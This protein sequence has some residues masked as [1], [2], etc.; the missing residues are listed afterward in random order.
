MSRNQNNCRLAEKHE[1]VSVCPASV[2]WLDD[3]MPKCYIGQCCIQLKS[4]V[5]R[6]DNDGNVKQTLFVSRLGGHLF[7]RIKS[8]FPFASL[9]RFGYQWRQ[10]PQDYSP[11]QQARLR[12][13]NYRSPNGNGG[14]CYIRIPKNWGHFLL[15]E[16]VLHA[17][18]GER[19]EPYYDAERGKMVKYEGD[20]FDGNPL[21]NNLKNLRWLPDFLNDRCAGRLRTLRN[22]RVD[23][24][25]LSRSQ[26]S[27][28]Y[29]MSPEDYAA[30]KQRVNAATKARSNSVPL[31]IENITIHVALALDALRTPSHS[32][33]SLN[34]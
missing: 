31:T 16:V 11:S 26:L 17:W 24:D 9:E 15:H 1:E 29:D 6:L 30:F 8:S 3:K 33:N 10:V 28:L 12:G 34:S 22:W 13:G 23:T 4:C 7:T 25:F 19:P 27:R 14:S 2:Q 32:F 20:H 5:E 21:N 18:V